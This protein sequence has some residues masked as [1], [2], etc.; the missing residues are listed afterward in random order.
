MPYQSEEDRRMQKIAD[1]L[2]KNIGWWK[3]CNA[4][5]VSLIKG[6]RVGISVDHETQEDREACLEILCRDN[7]ISPG[8][9]GL[10]WYQEVLVEFRIGG[11]IVAL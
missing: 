6:D 10:Y 7:L 4:Y 9:D 3:H 11:R 8:P 2:F 5:G 1:D